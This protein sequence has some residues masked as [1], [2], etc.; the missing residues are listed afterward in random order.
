MVGGIIA[1]QRQ[2]HAPGSVAIGSLSAPVFSRRDVIQ[3][4][5]NGG[6]SPPQGDLTH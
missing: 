3:R 4:A 2:R 5:A 6:A 1:D